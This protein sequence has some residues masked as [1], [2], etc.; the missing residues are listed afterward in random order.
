MKKQ[1]R[2]P[3]QRAFARGYRA[4]AERKSKDL[5]PQGIQHAIWMAGWREGRADNWDGL[6]GVSGIHKM[7]LA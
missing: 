7:G 1:K 6:V 2:N 4:G 3:E 5:A